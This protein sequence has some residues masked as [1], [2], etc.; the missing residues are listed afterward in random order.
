MKQRL[1]QVRIS[2]VLGGKE[3]SE[4]KGEVTKSGEW[5]RDRE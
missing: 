4:V 2:V 1:G 5:K 3:L